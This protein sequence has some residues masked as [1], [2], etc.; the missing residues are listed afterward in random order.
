LRFGVPAGVGDHPPGELAKLADRDEESPADDVG[1][2]G[3]LEQRGSGVELAGDHRLGFG[4]ANVVVEQAK[5]VNATLELLD[6][7]NTDPPPGSNLVHLRWLR[8]EPLVRELD[9]VVRGRL[10][11]GDRR[12]QAFRVRRPPQPVAEFP[13][14]GRPPG[15]TTG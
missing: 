15:G 7:A 5:L 10:G 9:R 3:L 4:A 14:P 1:V 11:G 13:V 6:C 8:D 12:R 2:R